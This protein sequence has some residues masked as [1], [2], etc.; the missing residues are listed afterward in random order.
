MLLA[1]WPAAAL[2][3]TAAA[4][5]SEVFHRLQLNLA[6]CLAWE[7]TQ[8]EKDAQ[9]REGQYEVLQG[10]LAQRIRLPALH[11]TLPAPVGFGRLRVIHKLLLLYLR[12]TALHCTSRCRHR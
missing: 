4:C 3:L 7:G 12:Y 8:H 6:A 2:A 1:D 9:R 11:V 5:G 10:V